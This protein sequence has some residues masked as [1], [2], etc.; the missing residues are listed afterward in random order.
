MK[1]EHVVGGSDAVFDGTV[2]SLNLRDMFISR[3]DVDECAH[4]C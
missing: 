1:R 3:D 4:V 2:V